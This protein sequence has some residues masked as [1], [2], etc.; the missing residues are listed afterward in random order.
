MNSCF[1]KDFGFK[2]DEKELVGFEKRS[3]VS[4]FS[5]EAA[6]ISLGWCGVS[7]GALPGGG[8]E[9]QF[10]AIVVTQLKDVGA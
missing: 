2:Q 4:D 10:R 1:C 5:V 7:V 6:V 8:G 9:T 3:K